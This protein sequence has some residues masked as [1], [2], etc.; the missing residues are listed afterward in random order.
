VVPAT[1]DRDAIFVTT[2]VTQSEQVVW[3]D[4]VSPSTGTGECNALAHSYCQYNST[5]T[6]TSIIPDIEMYTLLIDHSFASTV[7]ISGTA[8]AMNGFLLDQGGNK[9]NPCDSYQAF[10]Q[11]CPSNIAIGQIGMCWLCMHACVCTC[12]HFADMAHTSATECDFSRFP[13]TQD[14]IPLKTLLRAAGISSLDQTAGTIDPLNAE[15]YRYS[16]LV[17][18]VDIYYSNYFFDGLYS[19]FSMS[20]NTVKYY[21]SV[22]AI[23]NSDFKAEDAVTSR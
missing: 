15:T 12:R 2:R 21:Y 6:N 11:G 17:L 14:I 1:V 4:D 23:P 13:G 20:E 7:G 16:G 5:L 18:V 3:P 8:K 9:I 10:P 19:S 22:S